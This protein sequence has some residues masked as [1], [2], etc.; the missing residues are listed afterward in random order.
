MG[1]RESGVSIRR[2]GQRVA[3]LHQ[4]NHDRAAAQPCPRLG[5]GTRAGNR[6]SGVQGKRAIRTSGDMPALDLHS[7]EKKPAALSCGL[8]RTPH[9][10]AGAPTIQR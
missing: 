8:V 7:A 3:R 4:G 5:R 6:S 1:Q 9:A 10:G 2:E